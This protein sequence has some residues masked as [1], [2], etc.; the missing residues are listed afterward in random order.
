MELGIFHPSTAIVCGPTGSGKTIFLARFIRDIKELMFPTPEKIVYC[1][2]E[3]QDIFADLPE[4]EFREG[5]PKLAEFDGSQ[6]VLLIIDDLMHEAGH[7]VEKIFTRGSHHRNISVFF[8]T[9]NLF[10][11]SKGS[12]T[13]SLN[14]HYIVAFKSPRDIGQISVLARQIYGSNSK[15]MIEA[16]NDATSKPFGYLLIDLKPQT[17]EQLR[18]RTNIFP[19]EVNYA[20]IRKV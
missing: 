12:R 13:M 11:K 15:F 20:Y 19:D 10:F 18:L 1:Y 14:A 8:V 5:L 2:G 7:D 16:F 3:Y 6:R 17:P 4:V 9:Q